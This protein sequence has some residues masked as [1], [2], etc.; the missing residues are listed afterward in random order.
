LRIVAR[1]PRILSRTPLTLTPA[2]R[3]AGGY[4]VQIAA[5]RGTESIILPARPKSASRHDGDALNPMFANRKS[6]GHEIKVL[7]ADAHYGG[8]ANAFGRGGQRK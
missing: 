5:T 3:V 4:R 8:D 2:T 1:F 7:G 6:R